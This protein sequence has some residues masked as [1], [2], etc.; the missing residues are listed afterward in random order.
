MRL[1]I[2]SDMLLE[3]IAGRASAT[4]AWN[5]INAL[6]LTGAAELWVPAAAIAEVRDALIG[7][8]TDHDIRS[9]LRSAVAFLSVCSVDA[10]DIR[11]ALEHETLPYSVALTESCARKI[12]ADFVLTGTGPIALPRAIRRVNPEE[13]FRILEEEQGLVFDIIDF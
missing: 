1:L 8:L 4:A 5:K 3:F 6:E 9:A 7:E 11:F 13:L 2:E 10:A 12:Q